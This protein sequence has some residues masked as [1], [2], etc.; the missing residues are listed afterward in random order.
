MLKKIMMA[1]LLVISGVTGFFVAKAQVTFNNTLNHVN[2]D[3]DT[4][5]KDVDL[6]GIKVNS[7]ENVV[8]VLIV[9]NDYREEKGYDA[10]GLT[11]TMIIAT[12]DTKHK[13]LKLTSLMRDMAVDIP[14]HGLNKLNAANSFG[15]IQLLYK[16]IAQNFNI[17]LDGY[18]EV[19]FNAF[20]KIVNAVGG[21]EVELTESEAS[22]LNTTNYISKKR[23]RTVKVVKQKLNGNQALGYCRIRK[24]SVKTITG[25][26]DDYGRTWRQR[27]V[28]KCVFDKLK[29]LSLSKWIELA[30]EVLGEYVTTDLTNDAIMGY[31][32]DVIMM[33]T[34]E[35]TQLQIPISGYFRT[36]Y[37]GEYSCGSSLVLTDG[38]SSER[39]LAANAEALNKF[40]FE[41]D[42]KKPFEYGTFINDDTGASEES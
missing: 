12:M 33:G 40:V 32:K 13:N 41:Y 10:S 9:G 30:N 3:Y 27:T 18:V 28:I 4:A 34:T 19:G 11:D 26:M 2:R 36:S 5:L 6:S 20:E 24:G 35:V 37:D 22:Y 42:S 25:L 7:D 14:D 1:L 23:F 15:G 39:N 31:M 8:N 17:E 21:V 38:V 16:T 29:S